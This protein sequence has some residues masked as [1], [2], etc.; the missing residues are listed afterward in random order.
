MELQCTRAI[1]IGTIFAWLLPFVNVS[2][3]TDVCGYT[4]CDTYTIVFAI[5]TLNLINKSHPANPN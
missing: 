2:F 4:P 5:F 1:T 3:L